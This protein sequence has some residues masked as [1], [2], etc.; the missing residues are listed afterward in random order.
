M[1]GVLIIYVEDDL[2]VWIVI[3]KNNCLLY[4]WLLYCK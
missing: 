4:I 3:E 2:I 1:M